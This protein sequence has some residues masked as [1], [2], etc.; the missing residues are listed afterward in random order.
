VSER[1]RL[2]MASR[3]LLAFAALIVPLA[4]FSGWSYQ[5]ALDE[6]REGALADHVQLTRTIAAVLD[7]LLRDFDSTMIVTS[8]ALGAQQRPLNQETVGPLLATLAERYPLVRAVFLMDQDGRVIA[9]PSGQTIGTDLGAQPYVQALA[10]G[11]DFVLTGAI[12]G[13]QT[14]RPLVVMARSVRDA[15]G[16]LRGMLAFAF[17]PDRLSELFPGPLPPGSLLSVLDQRGALLY[18]SLVGDLPAGQSDLFRNVPIVQEALSGQV[19]STATSV[20]PLDGR[21]RLGAAA[22]LDYYGWVVL[23][24]RTTASIQQPLD[25]SFRREVI[26]LS[27]VT[28]IALALAWLVSRALTRP[29][30]RLARRARAM[31]RGESVHAVAIGGPP[32]VRALSEAF[33]A[34]TA[35]L[36][37]RLDERQTALDEARAALSVRDQFLSVAA[38]ELRTPLTAL[39]GHVQIARRRLAG[40]VPPSD[41]DPLL[42]RADGQVDRL[43]DLINDLLDVSR[44]SSGRLSIE[45]EPVAPVPLIRRVVELEGATAPSRPIELDLPETLPVFE[46]DAARLEQ[47]LFNLIENALKYSPPDSP[48]SVR[49]RL[50]D[51]CLEI[52]VSDRGA[53]IA[54][55]EQA[56]IFERFQRASNI[57]QNI[58]GLGL[59]L[60][61]S[62][63]IVEAHG[64]RLTVQSQPGAG[65]TFAIVLPLTPL[66]IDP[67]FASVP[68]RA[69]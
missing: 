65:S 13:V 39:K 31:S 48:V 26:A 16:A 69:E 52:S 50:V 15:Q 5:R 40:G 68:V 49:A 12:P 20:S 14:G 58:S 46:A 8:Q 45:R 35:E 38:H 30:E 24:S 33:N 66:P 22:P 1:L 6:R 54:S 51:G 42:R 53:G 2:G 25:E 19:A 18:T 27:A 21:Q 67:E 10:G 28:A 63:E 55:E 61:I 17:Y 57:D 3:L 29:L 47:V 64:G 37:Q 4:I 44:I 56:Q 32:E 59:G 36:Q 62:R 60:Y 41:L 11:E 43:T 34:L 23:L 7:T 9:S